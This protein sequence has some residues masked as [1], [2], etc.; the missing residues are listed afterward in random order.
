MAGDGKGLE[1]SNLALEW[2]NLVLKSPDCPDCSNLAP[3]PDSASPPS[4]SRNPDICFC[5]DKKRYQGQ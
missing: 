2:S 5:A 4:S 3:L 1:L